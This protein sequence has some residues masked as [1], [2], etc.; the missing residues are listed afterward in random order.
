MRSAFTFVLV[1]L[2]LQT[3]AGY[4]FRRRRRE[5]AGSRRH[6]L[7]TQGGGE[8]RPSAQ[9]VEDAVVSVMMGGVTL[10]LRDT[11]LT[12][13]PAKIDALVAMGGLQLVVPQ[14]WRVQMEVR[15]MFG[16]VR[17]S[18]HGLMPAER[19]P[20]LVVSG[21][22]IMGGVEVTSQSRSEARQPFSE[23]RREAA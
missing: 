15:P 18:R 7:V 13:R 2:I 20:D 14:D 5:A 10:D 17:D 22:V 19:E 3:V 8:F 12:S 6:F 16:G 4:M 11:E 21:R 1:W 23:P 9:E